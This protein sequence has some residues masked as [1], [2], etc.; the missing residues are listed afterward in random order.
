MRADT[1]PQFLIAEAR[2]AK[3]TGTYVRETVKVQKEKEKEGEEGGE[4]K[5]KRLEKTTTI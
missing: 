2:L 4:R 3:S 5:M 1:A